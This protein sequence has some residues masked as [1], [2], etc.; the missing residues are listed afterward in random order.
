MTEFYDKY[1]MHQILTQPIKLFGKTK[2]RDKIDVLNSL[3]PYADLDDIE[4]IYPLIFDKDIEL[5]SAAARIAASIMRKVQGKCWN[6]VYDT[7]KYTKVEFEAIDNL[8]KFPSDISIHLLGIASLNSNGYIREKAIRNFSKVSSSSAIPYILLRLNDW[9]LPVR[10]LAEYT[11]KNI[12]TIDNVEAFID[13]SYLLNKLQ[14]VLRADSI[15]T[16]ELIIDYLKDDSIKS[17][18]KNSLRHPK[19]KARLF[20]YMLL[21]DSISYDEDI[22]NSA[23]KDKSF[24]IRIWLVEA[25][26]KLDSEQKIATA[27]KLLNDKSAKVVTAVLRN[28]E[29]IVCL[30][31]KDVLEK[32]VTDNRASVRD[33]ARF[34]AKKHSLIRDFPE[35]YR[36]QLSENPTPGTLV[37]LGET[38]CKSDFT[39]VSSFYTFEN[40]KIRL[41]A[42]TAMWY[43]AK[44]EAIN[45]VLKELDSEIP[46]IKKTARKIILGSRMPHVIYEM[47][48]Y[49][50]SDKSDIKLFTLT[51]I[52]R[53]GG[54]RALEAILYAVS[55]WKSPETDKAKSFLDNW[56]SKSASLYTRPESTT[57]S[58]ITG[59]FELVKNKS[60]ISRELINELSFFFETRRL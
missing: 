6:N 38:G 55:F 24:E 31:F 18:I 53:Y 57:Y 58:N 8:L 44:D 48:T 19:V 17:K 52:C 59:L 39:L 46:K 47:K 32:L 56:L 25:I 10:S 7:V 12:L 4:Y 42:I 13:N 1:F 45:Y 50:K 26:K 30:E 33:E 29:D 9:V 21:R 15:N 41:A 2:I 51:A 34:I 36:K 37:G 14:N 22:I 5:S 49:L 11:L 28:F 16:T 54:W 35:Y 20:C 60:L 3:K 40:A 43:I 23:L 27:S